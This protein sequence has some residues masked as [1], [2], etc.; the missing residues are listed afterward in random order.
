MSQVGRKQK[1]RKAKEE[2][3]RGNYKQPQ[4]VINTILSMAKEGNKIYVPSYSKEFVK[5]LCYA[6][7]LNGMKDNIQDYTSDNNDNIK[8]ENMSNVNKSWKK[9]LVAETGTVGV[10]IDFSEKHFDVT[11]A[12]VGHSSTVEVQ[13]QLLHR[14]RHVKENML[15]LWIDKPSEGKKGI[16]S[17]KQIRKE[18][19]KKHEDGKKMSPSLL[20]MPSWLKDPYVS[21]LQEIHR[22]KRKLEKEVNRLLVKEHYVTE[23]IPIVKTNDMQVIKYPVPRFSSIRNLNF[24]EHSKAERN[25]QFGQA[26]EEQKLAMKSLIYQNI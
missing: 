22:S 15:Y 18:L 23:E 19:D 24:D 13:F 12:I 6:F 9:V 2:R 8:R 25:I 26:T 3:R 20:S 11:F 10:G 1:R 4:A 17:K 5:D 16:P 14:V 7:E 21:K